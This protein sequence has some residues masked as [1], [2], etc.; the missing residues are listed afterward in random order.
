[1][2]EVY[3]LAD[4]AAWTG[5]PEA[6]RLGVLGDPVA[7]SLSP[8]MQNAALAAAGLAPRYAKFQIAPNE[9]ATAL[10]R[11]AALGFI[12]VNLTVPHKVAGCSLVD[13]CD[14]F[15][16]EVGAINTIRFVDGRMQAVNTD[17][18]GFARAIQESFGREL[19]DL[20]V[21]LLGA[22]GGAGQ[23]LAAQCAR[24][25]CPALAL[26]N[27]NFLKAQTL[28]QRMARPEISA[29]RW[30]D[31]SLGEALAESDLVVNA[32][33]L[34]LH[35]G[36]PSPLPPKLR[37]GHHLV[38]DLNYQPTAFLREAQSAGLRTASGR[39]MLLHQGA[40]AFEF[41]FDRAAPLAAMRAALKL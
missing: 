30:S 31:D 7:H 15:A 10:A 2:K 18:P 16:R 33:P 19:G 12:G 40:L 38:Y 37:G 28:A 25:G 39:T 24:A 27:R 11:C 5:P 32:T 14:A 41:W 1:M 20:R 9:L 29:V 4:L 3:T 36:D 8:P 6:I 17:G 23:A 22:G 35:P 34:G 21:L 13:E 26:V